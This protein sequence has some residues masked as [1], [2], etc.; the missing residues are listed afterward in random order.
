[1]KYT[2]YLLLLSL[3][4][5]L[6][7]ASG[8]AQTAER[9]WQMGLGFGVLASVNSSDPLQVGPGA[10]AGLWFARRLHPHHALQLSL[11]YQ[12]ISGYPFRQVTAR[13]AFYPNE[14]Q[15]VIESNT[16][17]GLSYLKTDLSWIY[18]WSKQS[19]WTFGLGVQVAYLTDW[20]AGQ[21]ELA[22]VINSTLKVTETSL[23]GGQTSTATRHIGNRFVSS[24]EFHR[25]DLGGQVHVTYRLT[26]GLRLRTG[27]YQGL[28]EVLVGD[29][30][31][32][33]QDYRVRYLS[34][35]LQ[36]RLH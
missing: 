20:R 25:F 1:M 24:D 36:I 28:R 4:Y 29:L 31:A 10:Q 11:V 15:Q 3:F 23:G 12:E 32:D 35:G 33:H 27:V 14:Y 9:K 6:G 7:P 26:K 17:S 34:L 2:Y 18:R 22:Y 30:F 13:E 5:G 19:P 21:E 8:T 16:L